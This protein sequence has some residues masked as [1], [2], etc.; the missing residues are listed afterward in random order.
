MNYRVNLFLGLLLVLSSHAAAMHRCAV[1]LRAV[2]RHAVF[3]GERIA[4]N[5]AVA[6][7]ALSSH[8]E[9]YGGAPDAH[10]RLIGV[11]S[12]KN[13]ML[14]KAINNIDLVDGASYVVALLK[15]D[16]NIY[17]EGNMDLMFKVWEYLDGLKRMHQTF[18]KD[19][20]YLAAITGW[21]YEGNVADHDDRGGEL[22]MM[23]RGE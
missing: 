11:S 13:Q 18:S 7:R 12:N 17:A 1:I 6:A 21:K 8:P 20:D 5:G 15:I 22:D 10:G 9:W 19:D 2:A 16:A 3:Q 14:I 4:A 23:E